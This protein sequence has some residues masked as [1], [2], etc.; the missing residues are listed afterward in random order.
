MGFL[1]NSSK[2]IQNIGEKAKDITGI[3]GGVKGL[4][5]TAKTIYSIGKTIG[6]IAAMFI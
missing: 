3:I 5:D 6:P 2:L 1:N 4:V